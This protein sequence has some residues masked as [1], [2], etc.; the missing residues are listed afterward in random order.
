MIK[1]QV[2]KEGNKPIAVILDYAEYQKLKEAAEDKSDY[3]SAVKTK[4]SNKKW[5]AHDTLKKELGL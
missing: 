2:I 5:V 4:K 3:I 1:T